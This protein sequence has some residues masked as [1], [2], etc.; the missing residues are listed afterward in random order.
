MGK[1]ELS[2]REFALQIQKSVITIFEGC[3]KDSM[4]S[5]LSFRAILYEVIPCLTL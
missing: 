5:T 3:H 1:V 4:K 2:K